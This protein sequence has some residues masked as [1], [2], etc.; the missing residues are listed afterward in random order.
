MKKSKVTSS[1]MIVSL[2]V[3]ILCLLG[4]IIV[5]V[6]LFSLQ[7]KNNELSQTNEELFNDRST[8]EMKTIAL[9][10]KKEQEKFKTRPPQDKLNDF[11]DELTLK[12]KVGQLFIIGHKGKELSDRAKQFITEKHIGGFCFYRTN[13]S[14]K[15]QFYGMIMMMQ[16]LALGKYNKS[17]NSDSEIIHNIPLFIASDNEPGKTWAKMSRIIDVQ[18]PVSG[19]IPDMYSIEE[20]DDIFSN[21]AEELKYIGINLNFAPVVD[22]NTNPDNP[23]INERSFSDDPKVVSEYANAFIKAFDEKGIITTAKHFPGHG[24]TDSDSHKTLPHIKYDL[25]RLH[26]IELVPFKSV[27][28]NGVEFIMTAHIVY[29]K[30]DPGHPATLSK[31]VITDLLREDLN[32]KGVVITDDMYM[33]AIIDNYELEEAVV[34]SINAGVDIILCTQIYKNLP[35]H[36]SLYDAVIKA[37]EDGI[38]SEERLREAV[39]RIIELKAENPLI[40]QLW[41]SDN[42][43][44]TDKT[45]R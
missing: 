8:M 30:L 43:L 35:T 7:E 11:Y 3:L 39:M 9:N 25:E 26:N 4:L 6:N 18:L 20:A 44:Y 22:V 42:P 28:N 2:V 32:Y 33:K 31:K 17:E 45:S 19:E 16:N 24:D 23:I 36:E 21:F 12:Q 5:S 37:V 41:G 38:I 29:E 27:I 1:V 10:T 14:S 40:S 15:E 34:R 13:T